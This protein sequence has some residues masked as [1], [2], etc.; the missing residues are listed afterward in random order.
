[1]LILTGKRANDAKINR[2]IFRILRVSCIDKNVARMHVGMKKTITENLS[3]E[4]LNA[5]LSQEFKISV[6]R[7]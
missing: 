2:Y 5:T 7:F 4:Y 1:M 6:K 3:V